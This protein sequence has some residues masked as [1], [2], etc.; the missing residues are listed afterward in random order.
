MEQLSIYR[1]VSGFP[2]GKPLVRPSMVLSFSRSFSAT[3][4]KLSY[5]VCF[6]TFSRH[7]KQRWRRL[8]L[9][10]E[11]PV[12]RTALWVLVFA[13][14]KKSVYVGN[15]TRL[16]VSVLPRLKAWCY[17]GNP[18]QNKK[19]CFCVCFLRERGVGVCKSRRVSFDWWI[20]VGCAGR[21][22]A[23]T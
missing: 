13:C 4:V 2:V 17:R 23:G 16:G 21:V 5:S 10:D 20:S 11:L 9:C 18:G 19:N 12:S 15:A 22:P 6:L 1:S 3:R 7:R 14:T 8:S